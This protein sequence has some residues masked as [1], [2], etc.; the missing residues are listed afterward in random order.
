MLESKVLEKLRA[1]K[2]VLC[3]KTNFRDPGI[4][5][6][7]G[8]IGFDCVWFCREHLW[9]NDETLANMILAARATGMDSMVRIERDNYPSAIKPLE[10]G[11]KGIMVPHVATA[12]QAKKVVRAMRFSP[13][14]RRGIDG[15]NADSG[16]MSIEF[17]KYLKFSN[18]ETFIALQI[19]DPEAIDNIE[20]IANVSGFDILFVGPGDLSTSMGIPGDME[21]KEIW[22][23]IEK[24]GKMADK[25]GKIAGTVSLSP[26]WA[27]RL[28]NLGYR[29]LTAGADIVFLR[30]SFSKLKSEYKEL[31]F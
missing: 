25:H 9:S 2:P 30:K 13:I 21:N 31:G 20:E 8:L 14:G 5:E 23:V 18:K 26:E 6:M 27:K 3:T 17:K 28:V 15:V 1:G 7:I 29:F 4:V 24:V 10:M 11:A 12:E 22:K 19:E 16:W